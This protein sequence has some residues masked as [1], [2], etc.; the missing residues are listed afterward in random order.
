MTDSEKITSLIS[1]DFFLK[2]YIYT[3]VYVYEGTQESEFCDC[4]IET[5][6]A[7][8]VIQIKERNSQSKGSE[9]E[10]FKN[11]VMKRAKNQIKSSLSFYKD[12]NCK[13]FSKTSELNVDNRKDIIPIIVFL[14]TNLKTYTRIVYSKTL[15]GYI[16]IFSYDDFKTMLETI[17]L[18][19][20]ILNYVTFRTVFDRK[21]KHKIVIDNID[22]NATIISSPENE[23]EYAEQFLIRTYYQ[24]LIDHNLQEENIY[25]YNHLIRELNMSTGY[26]RDG[27]IEGLLC[28]DYL[29]ADKI[30]KNLTK[31]MGF[32]QEGK[33]A[34]PFKITKDDIVYMFVSKPSSLPFNEFLFRIEM[35]MIYSRYKNNSNTAYLIS[36]SYVSDGQYSIEVSKFDLKTDI[37]YNEYIDKVIEA[38]EE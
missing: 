29:R 26:A 16:N 31:I 1:K 7:Y 3:N 15:N 24:I 27:F 36:F 21:E 23:K 8:I 14:N 17:V 20:D 18:P 34:G 22:D 5:A 32:A 30:S 37:R 10:W 4:L 28:V 33:F 25:S 2:Q 6:S 38:L 35:E 12:K 19:Y 11:K 13:I 9:I